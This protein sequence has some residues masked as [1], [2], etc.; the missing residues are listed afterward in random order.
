MRALMLVAALAAMAAALA[1]TP[2]VAAADGIQWHNSFEE[3]LAAS[4]E[5]GKPVMADFHGP[6]CGWCE[7]LKTE[8]LV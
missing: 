3:A 6:G 1:A 5:S 2:S 8:T 7:L 4:A